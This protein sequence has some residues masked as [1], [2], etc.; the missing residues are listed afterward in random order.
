MTADGEQARTA[1]MLNQPFRKHA[2]TG[3]PHVIFKSA[4]SLDGKVATQTGDSKWISG[5]QSRELVHRWRSQ[6]DAICI[7]IGTALADDPLLTARAEPGAR[8]PHAGGLRQPGAAAARHQPGRDGPRGSSDRDRL[9]RRRAFRPASRCGRP[10][11]RLIVASG[12]TESERVVDALTKLGESGIQSVMLEG[13]PRLAGS[14][15]DA[16]Q[17]DEMRM[18]IAPIAVGGR[19][20]KVAFEG[21][22]SESIAESQRALSL[23]SRP[24]GEDLLVEARLKEW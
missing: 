7:G 11:P 6:V 4:I 21:E 17:I 24:V 22:G 8:Q 19:S 20:A 14:F 5:E 9:A 2:R 3:I 16:G 18:F 1:R 15:L 12:G 23:E 10:A 13:G